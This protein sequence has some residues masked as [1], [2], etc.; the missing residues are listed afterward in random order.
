[1]CEC[2]QKDSEPAGKPR[3]TWGWHTKMN[4]QRLGLLHL[5]WK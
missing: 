2:R 3:T 1:M 5:L 4:P